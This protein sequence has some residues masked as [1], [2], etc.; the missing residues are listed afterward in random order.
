MDVKVLQVCIPWS[1]PWDWLFHQPMHNVRAV[2]A[3][4]ENSLSSSNKPSSS[5]LYFKHT[6]FLAAGFYL[7]TCAFL[8]QEQNV[9]NKRKKTTWELCQ[10]KIKRLNMYSF[11]QGKGKW[12]SDWTVNEIKLKAEIYIEYQIL[13]ELEKHFCMSVCVCRIGD[14]NMY[15]LVQIKKCFYLLFWS[16]VPSFIFSTPIA[17]IHTNQIFFTPPAWKSLVSW[18]LLQC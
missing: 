13:W 7:R 1:S 11:P 5:W 6:W 14:T 8:L 12:Y 15:G 17:L 10:K 3:A 9:S 16:M 18:P 4:G 2:G